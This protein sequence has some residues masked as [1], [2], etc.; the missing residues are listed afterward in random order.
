MKDGTYKLGMLDVNVEN[1]IA[2]TNSGSLAGSTLTLEKAVANLIK[3]ADIPILEAV[4]MA[5]LVPAEFL[6]V[7]SSLGSIL[8]GKRAC[9]TMVD[10]DLNVKGTIVDGSPV[11]LSDSIVK[12]FEF[13][14]G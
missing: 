12:A 7:D 10:N 4:H 14:R 1:G 8:K 3:L 9:M 13:L 2:R 5:S 11:F 6:G